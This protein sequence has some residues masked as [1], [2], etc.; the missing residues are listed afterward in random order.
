MGVPAWEDLAEFYDEKQ[1][2]TGDLWHRALIDP[3]LFACIGTLPAGTRVLDLGCGNGYI[4]RR[5]S[6]AGARVVGVDSGQRIIGLARARES[7]DPLGIDYQCSDAGQLGFLRTASFD[8]V[9]SNMALMDM[10][11]AAAPLREAGRVLK[12]G[13]RLVASICHPCFDTGFCA[14]SLERIERRSTVYRKVTGYRALAATT[15]PWVLPDGSE[16][17]TPY[18]HRPL[19]WYARALS[20]SGLLI[21]RLEEPAPL[22]ELLSKNHSPQGEWINEVPLHLVIE[23]VR[24]DLPLTVPAGATMRSP[25]G[26][27]RRPSASSLRRR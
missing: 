24:A 17:R 15:G 3:V 13:G 23:A 25:D 10:A 2:D 18:Y 7:V 26:H 8:L 27:R 4:A 20:D 22:P 21:R 14:W 16:A 9:V 12:S 6:R 1:G 19:S 5:L 11:D